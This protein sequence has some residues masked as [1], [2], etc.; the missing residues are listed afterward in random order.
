MLE[1]VRQFAR[2]RLQASGDREAIERAHA[3]WCLAF[4][5]EYAAWRLGKAPMPS[6]DRLEAELDNMRAALAWA[7]TQEETETAHRIAAALHMF[8]AKTGRQREGLIWGERALALPGEVP[9]VVRALTLIAVSSL[10]VCNDDPAAARPLAEEGLAI[11]RALG[12]VVP[13]VWASFA[14]AEISGAED[15]LD[16]MEAWFDRALVLARALGARRW[17]HL[18]RTNLG[19]LAAERG[20]HKRA[21]MLMEESLQSARTSHDSQLVRHAAGNLASVLWAQGQPR[22]AAALKREELGLS[23]PGDVS[24]LLLECAEWGLA[25]GQPEPAARLLG[26]SAAL[27]ARFDAPL[28]R[29]GRS[30]EEQRVTASRAALGEP[31]FVAAWAAGAELSLKAAVAEAD[32]LLAALTAAPE[33][34]EAAPAAVPGG[35]T[36]RELEVLHLLADGLTNRGIAEALF[37][38]PRTV[39]NHVSNLL[40]KLEARTSREAVA[41]ARRLGI[42]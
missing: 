32:A 11:S 29:S 17:V 23:Q 24:G 30:L 14:L 3:A 21:I 5:E 27:R 13:E 33:P 15:D 36:P 25:A 42:L 38:S 4:V 9:P 26:A 39:D 35:L 31:A 20:D 2:E 34:T 40:A 19:R 37:I 41:K 6:P 12:E 28:P 18:F 16:Q 8:W 22:R 1:T 7:I 10:A